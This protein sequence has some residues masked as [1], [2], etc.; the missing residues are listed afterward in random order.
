MFIVKRVTTVEHYCPNGHRLSDLLPQGIL[1]LLN[2][3]RFCPVC[4][5]RVEERE[6]AY[7]GA[8]CADCM[9]P[10]DPS[11]NYCPYCGNRRE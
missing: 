4:G 8:Y 10:V 5:F 11:W 1:H 2:S 6:V 3:G 9:S 7:D